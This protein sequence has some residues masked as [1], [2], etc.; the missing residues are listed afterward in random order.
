MFIMYN[1]TE[2]YKP[3]RHVMGD[4]RNACFAAFPSAFLVLE[5]KSVNRLLDPSWGLVASVCRLLIK[6]PRLL[7]IIN[8]C[9]LDNKQTE[10]L[11][12]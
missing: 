12:P 3:I 7:K 11:L 9:D 5:L 4:L 8:L 10:V 2:S 6:A 1:A